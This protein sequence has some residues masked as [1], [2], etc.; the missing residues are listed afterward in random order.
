MNDKPTAHELDTQWLN[1]KGHTHIDP[2]TF[3]CRVTRFV[4]DGGMPEEQARP[5]VVELMNREA[6][7]A[8]QNARSLRLLGSEAATK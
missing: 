1:D 6:A 2:D 3:S 4:I 8:L 7:S 5:H